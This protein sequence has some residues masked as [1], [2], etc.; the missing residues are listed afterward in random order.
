MEPTVETFS[1]KQLP[2]D[3]AVEVTVNETNT[4]VHRETDLLRRKAYFEG[5][6]AKGQAGLDR[7]NELLGHIQNA[8]G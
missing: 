5:M 8:K 4:V 2:N 1:V 7:V 3:M 6:I